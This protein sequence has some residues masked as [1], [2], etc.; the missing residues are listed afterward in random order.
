LHRLRLAGLL[1]R[2]AFLGHGKTEL[3]PG[4][5]TCYE[6]AP[7]VSLTCPLV[8]GTQ[9]L[10]KMQRLQAIATILTH[11]TEWWDGSGQP[12]GLAGDEIPVESRILGLAAS[13]QQ[14]LAKHRTPP[15]PDPSS[16]PDSEVALTQ[17]LEAC[18]RQQGDRWDPKL[19][20]ALT[21]LVNGLKQ[22]IRLPM[23]VPKIASGLW[24]LDSH[25]SEKLSR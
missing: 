2:I 16:T 14:E 10:R 25:S 12:A 7:S 17:A 20:D 11:Q 18:C 1:H 15:F 22:G 19:I 9:M 13:F 24:L 21:L 3:T 6:D 8:P 23:F 5:L 4:T